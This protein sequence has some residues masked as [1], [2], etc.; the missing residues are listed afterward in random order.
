[1]RSKSIS[2]LLVIVLLL[3]SFSTALAQVEPFCGDLSDDDCALLTAATENMMDVASYQASAEYSAVLAGLPGLPLTEA[4][5]KVMV[6]GA[7][8]YA[9]NALEA[10]AILAG[11]Q[12]QEEV[13]ALMAESP[14][15]FVDF[16]NG[17]SF[18]MAIAVD[19][20][21]ELAAALSADAGVAIPASFTVPLIL[22]DGVLYVDVTDVAPLIDGMQDMTGWIGFEL[23]PV[24][25]AAAEQ[26]MFEEAAAQMDP[27]AMA[28]D[29]DPA[30]AAA[31]AGFQ[32]MMGDPKA[33]E[34]YM[35]ISRNADDVIDGVDVAVFVSKLDVIGLISSPEFVDLIKGLAEAGA[36]G[37]DAPSAADIDQAMTMLGLMGPMLFQGL[38]SENVTAVS[39]D[40]PNY[41]VAQE[42]LFSWD[43]SGLLQMAAMSGA[44]PANEIPSGAS[45]IEFSTSVV[46]SDFNEPQE[47]TAPAD[48]LMVPAESM[49][50]Q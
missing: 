10:A 7:F 15:V 47:I 23:G 3:A 34:P 24:I 28:A 50:Q 2:L 30:T 48:A 8:A 16:Y 38:T 39:L 49:M 1:M 25:E 19:I 17:W 41:I 43:L 13:A 31:L 12:T 44:I 22:V 33:F 42:S 32:A 11:A 18:D 40:E 26:G 21:E 9:D 6:D 35:T 37:E 46:N 20:S 5:V 14:D 45:L 36:L 29:M 27:S 4:S